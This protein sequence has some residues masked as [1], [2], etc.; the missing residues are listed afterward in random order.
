MHTKV[1]WIDAV[2]LVVSPDE[3]TDY[4]QQEVYAHELLL[5]RE[6]VKRTVLLRHLGR[7]DVLLTGDINSVA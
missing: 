7:Q 1:H 2:R 3:K 6:Q 4:D 5:K